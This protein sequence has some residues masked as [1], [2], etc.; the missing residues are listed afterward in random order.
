MACGIVGLQ[1]LHREKLIEFDVRLRQIGG[2]A[3]RPRRGARPAPAWSGAAYRCGGR[4]PRP[5]HRRSARRRRPAWR[6][7][8]RPRRRPACSASAG[9]MSSCSRSRIASSRDT[10]TRSR[11]KLGGQACVLGGRGGRSRRRAAPSRAPALRRA[12]PSPPVSSAA[13]A[14]WRASASLLLLG[15]RD[16]RAGSWRSRSFSVRN[17]VRRRTADRKAPWRASRG[18]DQSRRPAAAARRAHACGLGRGTASCRRRANERRKATAARRGPAFVAASCAGPRH[19]FLVCALTALMRR[20][21]SAGSP[22]K[23][24]SAALYAAFSR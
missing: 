17:W 2:V 20:S 12:P 1:P 21:S 3:L 22:R 4:A 13:S 15:G 16:V 24:A 23:R 19:A 11:A 7:A 14:A 9:G 18:S 10:E 8:P 5:R 6:R